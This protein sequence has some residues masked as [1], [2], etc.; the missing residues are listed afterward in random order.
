MRGHR[1]I[2]SIDYSIRLIVDRLRSEMDAK[3][4]R[5]ETKVETL[6]D[7]VEKLEREVQELQRSERWASIRAQLG[8]RENAKGRVSPELA[9]EFILHALRQAKGN[10]VSS[11]ELG[12]P[13][14]IGR[15]TVA[16]RIRE[17]RQEGY[18]ILSSPRKGYA[19]AE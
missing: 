6:A 5:L 19:L 10:Y 18:K 15:A 8:I 14:G 17:L 9:Q 16:A 2:P 12:G 1:K 4:R 11:S 7:R 13:L 3:V